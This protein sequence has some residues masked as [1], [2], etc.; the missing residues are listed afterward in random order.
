MRFDHKIVTGG[1]RCTRQT[2]SGALVILLLLGQP[3]W[4]EPCARQAEMSAFDVAKLKSQLM[5]TAL[6]CDVRDRY[7][8][9]VLRFRTDL[10]AKEH[11]LQ[12]YFS[13]AFGGRGQQAHDDYITTLANTQSEAGI[14][15][16]TLLCQQ[17]IGLFDAVLALP[18]GADLASFAGTRG[19]LI[20]PI[21]LVA[22]PA[23][24]TRTAETQTRR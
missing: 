3:A 24:V 5:V 21:D 12:G 20:Q 9:F 4:P 11:A 16:G 15:Q 18:K 14:K 19:D 7:N 2:L 10:M 1:R 6:A 23:S 17:T 8:D 13:R 22:C